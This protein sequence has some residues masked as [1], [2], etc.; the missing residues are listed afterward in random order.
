MIT[1]ILP[2]LSDQQI[3]PKWLSVLPERFISPNGNKR[4]MAWA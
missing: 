2:I 1:I 3:I 4:L